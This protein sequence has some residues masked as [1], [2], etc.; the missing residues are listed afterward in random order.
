M[1]VHTCIVS[2]QQI[3]T[4]VPCANAFAPRFNQHPAVFRSL[5]HLRVVFGLPH[6]LP[7]VLPSYYRPLSY[8]W[9]ICQILLKYRNHKGP[10]VN[11]VSPVADKGL[12]NCP[13]HT[14]VKKDFTNILNPKIF[15]CFF[16][17]TRTSW[18]FMQ[19]MYE[20]Y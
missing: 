16:L 10:E 12:W 3:V 20:N 7:G 19:I 5:N 1:P 14:F 2:L 11:C 9:N 8:K 18:V 6:T 15:S 4:H 13:M 17:L